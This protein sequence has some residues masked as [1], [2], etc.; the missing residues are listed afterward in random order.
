MIL[1]GLRGS[2]DDPEAHFLL[3]NVEEKNMASGAQAVT[4]HRFDIECD[5][6]IVAGHLIAGRGFPTV[7]QPLFRKESEKFSSGE[8]KAS[9]TDLINRVLAE[10][11]G[12]MA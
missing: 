8:R 10:K 3:N 7:G 11:S 1:A 6:R 5:L 12:L 9:L 4:L 2:C